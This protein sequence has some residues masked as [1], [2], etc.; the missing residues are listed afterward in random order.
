VR[1]IVG[2]ENAGRSAGE[3]AENPGEMALIVK[4]KV[5]SDGAKRKIRI[6]QTIH[7]R[8]H[9]NAIEIISQDFS[10]LMTK[11]LAPEPFR[12]PKKCRG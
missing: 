12:K 3:L 10:K 1:S 6:S 8:A 9:A 4:A 2:A 5:Q 11:N 7:R